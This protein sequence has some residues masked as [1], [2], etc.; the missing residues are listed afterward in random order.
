MS[1][2][3]ISYSRADTAFVDKLTHDLEQRGIPVWIDRQDIEGGAAWRASISQA[4]RS[5]CAFILILSPRSTQSNQV[6][7]ELSV[8][9]THNR[10]IIPVVVE[11]C[12]I[13]PGME[14]QLAELQWI[15]FADLSYDAALE[16]LTRVI[17]EARSRTAAGAA[18]PSAGVGAR[19]AAEGVRAETPRTS[20]A[21]GPSSASGNRKWLVAGAAAIALAGV[22]FGA[23]HF[24]QKG[25]TNTASQNAARTDTKATPAE[26]ARPV[27][28]V[29]DV[30]EPKPAVV[31][32]VT[33]PAEI[34]QRIAAPAPKRAA[35]PPASSS[36]L[37]QGATRSEVQ[38]RT[39]TAQPEKPT[40]VARADPAPEKPRVDA[41]APKP[42][43]PI[44]GNT[45]TKFYHFP[46]CPNYLS[47]AQQA[48]IEFASAGDAEAAGYKLSVN[49]ADP[50]GGRAAAGVVAN[51]RTKEYFLPHCRGYAATGGNLRVPFNSANE[52][53]QA[54]Y[55]KG[56]N[57]T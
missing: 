28:V 24:A 31:P 13:P 43:G 15:S 51:S 40:V 3:F 54:G 27:P 22:S 18:A 36:G 9:E 23:F 53:E 56:D 34:D 30:G 17:N 16:R 57:C 55:R 26:P 52:A 41:A 37:Q 10:L 33:A 11:Q 35:P 7:K 42:A 25:D 12:D 44:V 5:C 6:S 14:L 48:R 20:A 39:V 32:T 4:I 21:R 50:S 1:E 38:P 8:A 45:R 47:V 29:A 46:G 49:C 2:A 19:G